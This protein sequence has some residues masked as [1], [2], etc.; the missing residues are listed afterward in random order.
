MCLAAR[1]CVTAQHV[2]ALAPVFVAIGAHQ[3]A[4]IVDASSHR[5]AGKL[6]GRDR[7]DAAAAVHDVAASNAG[8][9]PI[10]ST[11]GARVKKRVDQGTR[12]VG[13]I[14]RDVLAVNAAVTMLVLTTVEPNTDYFA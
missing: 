12:G 9:I 2:T 6:F 4:G 10:R 7:G 11:D 13:N 3:L 8:I 14:D 1:Q 5:H